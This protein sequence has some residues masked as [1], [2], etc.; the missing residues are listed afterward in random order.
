MFDLQSLDML[1]GLVTIYLSIALACTAIVESIATF[2][3]IRSKNLENALQEILACHIS[4]PLISDSPCSVE[5]PEQTFMMKFFAHSLVNSLSKGVNGR[6]SYIPPEIFSQ[7]VCDI[8]TEKGTKSLDV[9]INNLP[10]CRLKNILRIL[11]AKGAQTT[12]SFEYNLETHFDRVMD[13]ATGWVKIHQQKMAVFVS[14]LLVVLGNVD[15][16]AIANAFTA[17]SQSRDALLTQ[18]STLLAQSNNQVSQPVSTGG[19]A[20]KNIQ[21]SAEQ[22][23]QSVQ[24][25]VTLFEAVGLPLGWKSVDINQYSAK[26]WISKIVGWLISIFAVSLG[27][28]FWFDKLQKIVNIRQA[29]INPREKRKTAV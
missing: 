1:I 16:F 29:G 24:A 7:V 22:V 15:T 12:E 3:D 27:A 19:D 18:A 17:S 28:P 13:R 2:F 5:E 25:S 20:I 26:D 8:L 10:E 4:H 23:K 14:F 6:P 11:K 21:Q 9:G